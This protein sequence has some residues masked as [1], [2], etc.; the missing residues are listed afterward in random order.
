M[1]LIYKID[2]KDYLIYQ[3][4]TA[5]KSDNIKKK[6]QKSKI[7]IPLIYF[8]FGLFYSFY[9]TNYALGVIFF[10]ISC[11]WYFL[12]PIWEKRHYIKH[13]KKFIA[14]NYK[15]SIGRE[16]NFEIDNEFLF[17]SSNGSESK[18]ITTEIV[19]INEIPS[20][21]FIKLKSGQS[22]IFPKSKIAN[23]NQVK[24]RLTTLA[25]HLNINYKDDPQWEWK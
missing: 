17:A 11:L 14:E 19:E 25:A 15:D 24:T 23:I 9:N 13:Y 8:T 7:M 2:E 21:I 22:F 1:T 6:R 3:L 5:S 12:Y 18:I 4:F 16:I 10:I 20:S